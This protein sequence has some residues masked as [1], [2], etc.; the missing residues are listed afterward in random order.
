M[1]LLNDMLGSL[2]LMFLG[3]FLRNVGGWLL[4]R[5]IYRPFPL[6]FRKRS[7]EPL[8]LSLADTPFRL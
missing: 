3:V 7:I 4:C 6:P 5:W 8:S 1:L 2:L